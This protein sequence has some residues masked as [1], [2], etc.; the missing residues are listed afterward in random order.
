MSQRKTGLISQDF[1]LYHSDLIPTYKDPNNR[2]HSHIISKN[3]YIYIQMSIQKY[4][5]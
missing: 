1:P 5:D 3:R 2:K 4:S